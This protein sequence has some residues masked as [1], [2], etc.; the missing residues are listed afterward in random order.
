M[1][2]GPFRNPFKICLKYT[3]IY[4]KIFITYIKKHLCMCITEAVHIKRNEL[5]N[6]DFA[7]YTSK[8]LSQ[9]TVRIQRD[10]YIHFFR[11]VM[12]AYRLIKLFF[13]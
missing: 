2:V 11:N 5:T 13:I 10:K 7:E 3:H 9:A 4:Q 1:C 12:I 6:N 8:W